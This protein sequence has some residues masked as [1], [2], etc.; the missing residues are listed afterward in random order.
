MAEKTTKQKNRSDSVP[1]EL[2]VTGFRKR[3]LFNRFHVANEGDFRVI[4]FGF[5]SSANLLMDQFVCAIHASSVELQR[6]ENLE[7]L[8]RLGEIS[9]PGPPVW[10]PPIGNIGV[11]LA[12]HMGF[13]RHGSFTEITVHNFSMKALLD[14]VRSMKPNATLPSEPVAILRSDV[15]TQ[16]HFLKEL[17]KS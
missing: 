16:K 5:T 4:H 7:Y 11:E 9:V 3:M 14:L 13:C 6:S 15:E 10:Q 1:I 12:T 8:G 2:A 17:Y